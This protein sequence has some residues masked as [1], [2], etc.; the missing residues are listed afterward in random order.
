MADNFLSTFGGEKF[1]AFKRWAVVFAGCSA[2][3]PAARS[4]ADLHAAQQQVFTTERAFAKTM[5][6]RDHAAFAT[7]LAD[8]TIFFGSSEVLRGKQQVAAAWA[9]FYEGAEAPFSWEPDTV[10]VL[11]SG[12]WR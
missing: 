2:T 8:E 3:A 7:F 1:E 9:R 6:D 5:A 10:E 12:R 11:D 4:Q